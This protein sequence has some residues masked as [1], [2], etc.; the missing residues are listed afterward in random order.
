MKKGQIVL[1]VIV[2]LTIS[3]IIVTS[4]MTR[5]L[6][7][8]KNTTVN[9]DSARAF[10]AAESGIEE[11]LNRTDLATIAGNGQTYDT[12]S[13]DPATFSERNYKAEFTDAGF[14]ETREEVAKDTVLQIEFNSDPG[15]MTRSY[16]KSDACLLISLITASGEVRRMLVCPYGETRIAG[17]QYLPSDNNCG[18]DPICDSYY[19]AVTAI[20]NPPFNPKIILIKPLL[21]STKI[22][23]MSDTYPASF[24]TKNITGSAWA[25][26]NSGVKKELEAV[27]KTTKDI[28]PV[29]DYALYLR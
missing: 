15:N 21:A 6:T 12:L 1:F 19:N 10:N 29:F 25:K 5:S 16:F 18:S 11:L 3:L 23:I 17:V 7:S 20:D 13:V 26:T 8:I 4:V 28:Y 27:T 14:F 9:T 2:L 22:K 24:K